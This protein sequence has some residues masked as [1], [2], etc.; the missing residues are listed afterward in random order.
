M[1]IRFLFRTDIHVADRSPSSWKADYMGEIW[2]N[3]DQIGELARKYECMAVLDGGDYFH[4]KA[5]SKNSHALVER[6]IQVHRGYPCPTYCIEGN[7]DISY[8]N[9][10]TLS[11]QPLGVLYASGA[12]RHLR[13][14]VFESGGI[15]VR[16][17]G[18][19]YSPTRSLE[20][21]RSIQKQP[22][23]DYL[24]VIIH[25]LAS[26]NPPAH[27][28]EFFGEPVFRYK[29]LITPDGPDVFAFGHWHR[30]Q[31]VVEIEGRHF[32]NH[33]AVSRGSL[34]KENLDRVPQVSIIEFG[35][36]G[37]QVILHPLDVIPASEAF[38]ME[39]KERE[40]KEAE[41]IE[42][43]VERLRADANLS[44][45]ETIEDN[46]SSLSFAMDVKETALQYLTQAR[47]ET[48]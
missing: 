4:V 23:D 33:G 21:I 28:E 47:L 12:F 46:V 37:V 32:V 42:S 31:G 18:V 27:V 11:R 10:D 25:Q 26:E 48:R 22:G 19:P 3:L 36:K 6:S 17:V 44:Q 39:R 14:E 9:L 30:D 20:D 7:H 5:A 16:V 45:T 1:A 8:N 2:S 41:Q 43:F 35:P 15:R 40:D 29:D 38:D 34:S 24:V 13:D